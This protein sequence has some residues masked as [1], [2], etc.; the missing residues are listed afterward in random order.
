MTCHLESDLYGALLAGDPTALVLT[1]AYRGGEQA[2]RDVVSDLSVSSD[3]TVDQLIRALA[4]AAQGRRDDAQ[5]L[6]VAAIDALVR[7]HVAIHAEAAAELQAEYEASGEAALEGR[8][9]CNWDKV[10]A[11]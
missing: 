9:G 1:P 3:N 7:S 4:A 8:Y 2:L 11:E 5:S 6:A 10:E